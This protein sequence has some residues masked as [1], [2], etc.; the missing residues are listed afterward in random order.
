MAYILKCDAAEEVVSEPDEA[1]LF[2]IEFMGMIF[3]HGRRAFSLFAGPAETDSAMRIDMDADLGRA[4]ITWLPDGSHG[5]EHDV[6][7]SHVALN[8]Y[9]SPDTGSVA[10][11]AE[12]GRV[13]PGQA[14]AAL[15]EYVVTGARPTGLEWR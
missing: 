15:G 11:P 6:P 8:V 12:L 4:A 3:P 5:A 2:M 10:V 9:E 14:L 1:W 13:T 7:A